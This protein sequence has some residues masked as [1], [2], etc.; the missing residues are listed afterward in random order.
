MI[1]WLIAAGVGVYFLGREAKGSIAPRIRIRLDPEG[2]T[3]ERGKRVD[4]IAWKDLRRVSVVGRGESFDF[5]LDGGGTTLAIPG[6]EGAQ[7]LPRLQQLP[8]F[9]SAHVVQVATAGARGT[10]ECWKR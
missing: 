9:D 1:G 5:V 3:S 7:L 2:V 10:F 8:G 4:R 6:A